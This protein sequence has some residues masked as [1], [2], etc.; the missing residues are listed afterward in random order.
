MYVVGSYVCHIIH[1]HI[2]SIHRNL[3]KNEIQDIGAS[4]FIELEGLHHL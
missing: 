2:Y 1:I 3:A 4:V